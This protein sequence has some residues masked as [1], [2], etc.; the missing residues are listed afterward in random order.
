MKHTIAGSTLS[1]GGLNPT[2]D[3]HIRPHETAPDIV[4]I[5]DC[6]TPLGHIRF[7][8]GKATL[9][10]AKP[11]GTT[12]LAGQVELPYVSQWDDGFTLEAAQELA[13]TF[14]M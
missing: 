8:D 1:K 4:V 11:F 13:R 7:R 2:E 12:L 6:H 9:H 5:Y 3:I 10:W 14:L